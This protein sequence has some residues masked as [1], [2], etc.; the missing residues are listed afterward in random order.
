MSWAFN[1]ETMKLVGST[2]NR[3]TKNKMVKMC[4]I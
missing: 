1:P 4:H 2:E 3:T